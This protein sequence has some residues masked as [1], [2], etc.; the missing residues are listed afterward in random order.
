M[1]VGSARNPCGDRVAAVGDIV[2]ARLYSLDPERAKKVLRQLIWNLNEESGG[3]GWGMPEAFGEILAAIPELQEEYA[4]L[5]VAYIAEERCFIENE[6]VQKGVIWGLGRIKYFHQALRDKVIPFL[7]KV[8]K[9]NDPSLQGTAIW[10]VGEM[11][12]R[13][14]VPLIKTLRI[15][16]R[17][18]KIYTGESLQEK[19][20]PQWVEEA[21]KKL[22]LDKGNDSDGRKRM[23][24]Q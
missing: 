14:A 9:N 13:E 10:S 3:I 17:M 16:N 22:E 21:L 1:V 2:T 15:E 6:Q 24:M 8:L 5:L 18:L 7:L 19:P 4:C 23:E 12:I 20:L 11:G